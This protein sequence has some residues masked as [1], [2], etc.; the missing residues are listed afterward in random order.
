MF[1]GQKQFVTYLILRTFDEAKQGKIAKVNSY[2]YIGD[3]IE[4]HL[5]NPVHTHEVITLSHR[6][7][8]DE[9][10]CSY[11]GLEAEDVRNLRL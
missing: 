7:E 4:I 11:W 5:L 9:I 6:L 10:P 1:L 3:M 2:P 8:V